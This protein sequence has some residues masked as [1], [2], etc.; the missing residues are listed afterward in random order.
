MASEVKANKISPATVTTVTLGDASDTFV[1]P[2]SV[3]LDVNGIIDLTGATKTGFPAGGLAGV[4]VYTATSSTWTKATRESTLGITITKV[5]VEVQ[6]AGG[7]GS[8]GNTAGNT[9]GGAGGGYAR[10]LLDVSDTI[11]ATAVVGVGGTTVGVTNNPGVAG[12]LSNFGETSGTG[13][14][15]T[16]IGNGGAAGTTAGGT[17][18]AGGTSSGGD[19]QI[20]GGNGTYGGYMGSG[21]DSF[22]GNAGITVESTTGVAGTGYGAGGGGG[23]DNNSGVG[24]NGSVIVWEYQ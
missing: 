7:S 18:S 15:T 11:T 5:I 10:K 22:M 4:Q 16:V 1:I 17:G 13:G 19:I 20:T 8:S 12:G 21:G 9:M 23:R 14:W 3:T 2:A 6:G 24:T